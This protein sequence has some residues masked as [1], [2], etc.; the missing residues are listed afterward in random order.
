MSGESQT[1]VFDVLRSA[2]YNLTAGS[3]V[4]LSYSGSIELSFGLF[5][6]PSGITSGTSYR[7][8]VVGDNTIGSTEVTAS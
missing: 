2:G 4:H 7:V 5:A 8:T 6:Q 1:S 3:L